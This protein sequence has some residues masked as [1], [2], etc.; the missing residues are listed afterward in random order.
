MNNKLPH[1]HSGHRER[2]R[3]K[4]RKNFTH[5]LT[6]HEL[7]EMVLYYVYPRCDT[8]EKAHI[9]LENFGGKLHNVLEA[10]EQALIKAGLTPTGASFFK[11]IRELFRAYNINKINTDFT[12][13]DY[14]SLFNYSK[15]LISEPDKEE[16]YVICF[17]SKSRRICDVPAP[18]GLIK[19]VNISM[20]SIMDI[21]VKNNAYAVVLVHNHPNGISTPSFEDV[22]ATRFIEDVLRPVNISVADHI[23]V[24]NG[25]ATSMRL[26]GS[27]EVKLEEETE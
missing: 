12:F 3:E 24:A 17:D 27:F 2:M 20:R 19:N 1:H 16:F 11:L 14:A 13:D 18:Y 5:A 6:D 4:L 7:L 23:I 22:K 21:A 15:G 10:D 8:N 26:L 25:Q 9:L